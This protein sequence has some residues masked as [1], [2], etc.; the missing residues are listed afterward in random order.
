[1]SILTLFCSFFFTYLK[2]QIAFYLK[3]KHSDISMSISMSSLL[4]PL[5]LPGGQR[6]ADSLYLN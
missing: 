3:K 1:M 5:F 4:S 2:K 6:P